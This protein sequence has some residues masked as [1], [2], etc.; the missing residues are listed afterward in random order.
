M[1]PV[2]PL[3]AFAAMAMLLVLPISTVAACIEPGG[4]LGCSGSA[5]Y[6]KGDDKAV[7][8][9]S[10]Y[11]KSNLNDSHFVAMYG[12]SGLRVGNS[13]SECM[14]AASV[15]R[16][17]T[18]GG[19]PTCSNTP[20]Y[21]GF[22]TTGPDCSG[23]GELQAVV[24]KIHCKDKRREITCSS[25][26][27][28]DTR[29]EADECTLAALTAIVLSAGTTREFMAFAKGGHRGTPIGIFARGGGTLSVKKLWPF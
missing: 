6:V 4:C 7:T 23:L 17:V 8:T 1:R 14:V 3:A 12:D 16:A 22:L 15:L 25:G 29:P 27:N 24:N 28:Q 21:G 10:D 11:V 20:G 26:E 9:L 5:G 19:V 18:G 2:S 13:H